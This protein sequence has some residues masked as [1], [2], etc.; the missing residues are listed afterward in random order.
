VQNSLILIKKPISITRWTD[1]VVQQLTVPKSRQ[2]GNNHHTRK[3]APLKMWP[4][5]FL[6]I[7]LFKFLV[8][9]S[10]LCRV[11]LAWKA[12]ELLYLA[13]IQLLLIP[14]AL[15]YNKKF[16]KLNKYSDMKPSF[17]WIR[18]RGSV[19]AYVKNS[20]GTSMKLRETHRL[21]SA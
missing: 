17:L 6:V 18:R 1:S 3:E 19:S 2:K 12:M 9:T 8:E 4:A 20:L 5:N 16:S 13:R 14:K 21:K 10:K 15:G 11:K 7:S